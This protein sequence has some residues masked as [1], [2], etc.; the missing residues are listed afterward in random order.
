M[1][2][3]SGDAL[4]AFSFEFTIDGQT[5]PQVVAV[6]GITQSADIIETKSMTSD[7]QYVRAHMVGPQKTG[8]L[9]LKCLNTGDPG[10]TEWIMSG[11]KG[12]L[13][14]ARKPGSLIYKDTTGATI[15]T[16]T[17]Q[18]VVVESIDYGDTSAG[19]PEALNFTLSLAF[20]E[21]TTS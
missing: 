11:L 21:M 9:T 17:F 16:Q 19:S 18:N 6:T 10:V 3:A 5:I 12:Q 13:N 15:M 20:T 8:K 2:L 1:A 4:T 7:G 14:Q